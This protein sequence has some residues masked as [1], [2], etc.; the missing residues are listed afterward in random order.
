M[1]LISIYVDEFEESMR[2]VEHIVIFSRVAIFQRQ[3]VVVARRYVI[4]NKSVSAVAGLFSETALL[5]CLRAVHADL[6]V[7]VPV[8]RII[9]VYFENV[10]FSFV[11]DVDVAGFG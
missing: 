8:F 5:L 4:N 3:Q 9:G 1:S 2:V 11:D 7:E 6:I 10:R